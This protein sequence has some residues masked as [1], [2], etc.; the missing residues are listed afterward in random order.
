MPPPHL[1]HLHPP[2]G[3]QTTSSPASLPPNT[4]FGVVGYNIYGGS[5]VGV[6]KKDPA[7]DSKGRSGFNNNNHTR[8]GQY[9]TT[10]F[11]AMTRTNNKVKLTSSGVTTRDV[12]F[13]RKL[14]P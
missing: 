9:N 10:T 14:L 1:Q 6:N 2:L 4:G 3:G 5:G 12:C 11:P 13:A 8:L 7:G